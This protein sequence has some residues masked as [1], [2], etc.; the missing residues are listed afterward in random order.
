MYFL[1]LGSGQP[2]LQIASL[3]GCSE[4]HLLPIFAYD[5]MLTV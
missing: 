1:L 3:F 5:Q 2:V 4:I